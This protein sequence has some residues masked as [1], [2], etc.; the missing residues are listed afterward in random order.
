MHSIKE[1]AKAY[2][3]KQV[4]NIAELP[5]VDVNLNLSEDERT[6]DEGKKFTFKYIDVNNEQYRVPD[7]V[8]KSLKAILQDKPTLEYFKV[9]KTGEGLKTQYT[10]VPLD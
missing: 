10:V 3:S 7:S 9:I 5:K 8:L 4:K 2:E 6:D 1:W